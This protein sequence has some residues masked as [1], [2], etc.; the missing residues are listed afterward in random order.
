MNRAEKRRQKKIAAKARKK[1]GS[2][3][4]GYPFSRQSMVTIGDQ[5]LT[6]GDA[7]NLA[8]QNLSS[9]QTQAT[10]EI[11]EKILEADSNQ[12]N[13]LHLL[14]VVAFELGNFQRAADRI[15]AA[16]A[17]NPD[18]VD[19]HFNLGRAY[20]ELGQHDAAAASYQKTVSLNP[21][22]ADAHYNLS[23][24]Y[25]ELERLEEA[26]THLKKFLVL[27][28]EI[29]DAH[30]N[31]G[32]ILR[33]L[34]RPDEA[35]ECF[36]SA[37]ALKPNFADFYINRSIALSEL[38][39]FD[40]AIADLDK[41]IALQPDNANTYY[42]RGNILRISGQFDAAV[43]SYEKATALQPDFTDAHKNLGSLLQE[44]GQF[45]RAIHNLDYAGNRFSSAQ[46]LECLFAL[47]RYDEFHTKL[48]E[49]TKIDKTNIRGAAISAFAAHQLDRE[50]LYPFCKDPLDFIHIGNLD[51]GS[52]GKDKDKL[53]DAIAE[54]LRNQN[55]VWEPQGTTTRFGYQ[56]Q[57]NLF[58]EPT[59]YVAALEK[60]I[61]AEI[62]AYY[63]QRKAMKCSFMTEWPNDIQLNGWFVRLMGQGHQA[64][65][66][67]QNGWLSGVVYLALPENSKEDEGAIQFGLHGYNYPIVNEDYPK[68]LH[69]PEKGQ[70]VL[71]PSSLFHKTVPIHAG[72]ERLSIAFD[73]NPA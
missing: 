68:V 27:K 65:H 19:G 51:D 72:E 55:A 3:Q 16:V 14:G 61:K 23:F 46:T 64:D 15:S 37:I 44:L 56:T 17:I 43:T 49:L 40:A 60:L 11:C 70:I 69:R 24:M 25:K 66:I 4:A 33:T 45:E 63:S 31:L 67:H 5:V 50:D 22:N 6:T 35:L 13:A 57:E 12:P 54:Q 1:S 26:V 53:V 52:K 39:Q 48:N 58:F 10:E 21:N 47:E 9:G 71:F 20:T 32:I 73:L 36:N 8:L 42:Q 41:A 18:D 59:G 2:I 34:G 38:E 28:P 30:G 7:I 29:S 62:N